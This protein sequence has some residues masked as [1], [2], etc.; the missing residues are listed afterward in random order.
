MNEKKFDPRKLW[1]LNN[2]A[3]L[4]D[5]PPALI[6]NR[7]KLE[8]PEVLVDLGA[9]TAFFSLAFLKHAP[10]ATIYACDIADIMLDWIKEHVCPQHPEIIPV[11]MA[12]RTVPLEDE[13]ADLVFMINLHHELDDP[14]AI[15]AESRRILKPKGKVA[16]IDWKKEEMAEGPPVRIRRVPAE[17][18]EELRQA[19]FT[20]LERFNELPKHFFLVGEKE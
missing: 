17:V 18:R 1:K 9:G 15:L 8:K 19:G 10:A 20:H 12:E 3:R 6:W 13:R 7:L 11:K 16:I 2:P 5:L 14:Q 4:A